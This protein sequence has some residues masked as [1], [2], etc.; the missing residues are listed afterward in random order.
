M[1]VR[2]SNYGSRLNRFTLAAEQ[3]SNSERA[4]YQD[5]ADSVVEILNGTNIYLTGMMGSGKTTVGSILAKSLNYLFMDT[6]ALIEQAAK[7]TI[8]EIFSTNG[9]ED[10]RSIETAVLRDLHQYKNLVVST[11]GGIVIKAENWSYLRHGIV[12]FLNCTPEKLAQRV[13]RDGLE[14]RP[15]LNQ[16]QSEKI[17]DPV[18]AAKIQLRKT[19]NNRLDLY[20]N[21]DVIVSLEDAGAETGLAPVEEVVR[22]ILTQ[23]N[24][25]LEESKLEREKQFEYRVKGAST[26]PDGEISI[27]DVSPSETEF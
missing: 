27:N 14:S 15:I 6:D 13:S 18:E 1:P 12:V 16:G 21:A 3:D 5:T 26:R 24:A 22:R 20:K 2:R 25:K 19:Y 10:F 7:S 11:G 4:P 8:A 9:E 23:L 17:D